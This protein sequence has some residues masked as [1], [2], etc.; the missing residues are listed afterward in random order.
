MTQLHTQRMAAIG[1]LTALAGCATPIANFTAASTKNVAM[2]EALPHGQRVKGEDCTAV[3]LFPVRQISVRGAV[4]DALRMAG[5]EFDLLS[6]VKIT[7][8]N[9]SFL[10]GEICFEV[11]ALPLRSGARPPAA[12]P[13]TSAASDPP[14]TPTSAARSASAK[15]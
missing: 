2:L 10:F 7:N 11:E 5:P 15:P 1:A 12:P 8:I 3:I 13:A 14:A 4:D 9:R 6:D